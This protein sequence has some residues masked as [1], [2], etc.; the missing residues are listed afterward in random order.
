MKVVQASLVT[1]NG[2]SSL[3]RKCKT[4]NLPQHPTSNS[5]NEILKRV[6][7][8]SCSE[9]HECLIRAG[10]NLTRKLTHLIQSRNL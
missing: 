6:A 2:L 4:L 10:K 9:A 5:Y 3:K 8:A 7:E 1:G